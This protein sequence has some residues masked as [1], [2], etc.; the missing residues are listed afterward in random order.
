[1]EERGGGGR[2][3]REDTE[4]GREEGEGRREKGGEVTPYPQRAVQQEEKE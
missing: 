2:D 4:D 3:R 1:V